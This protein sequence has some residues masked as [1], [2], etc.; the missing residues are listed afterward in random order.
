M[1][2][3]G[4]TMDTVHTSVSPDV[5]FVTT[6]APDNVLTPEDNLSPMVVHFLVV[7]A[8][9]LA[10]TILAAIY[11]YVHRRGR[12]RRRRNRDAGHVAG[13]RALEGRRGSDGEVLC[14]V[15]RDRKRKMSTHI[16]LS[17]G[18][19]SREPGGRRSSVFL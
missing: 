14:R 6:L 15:D 18:T 17:M 13:L 9:V 19:G 16:V 7:L 3:E 2:Y 1:T 5:D 4:V 12:G 8:L 10:N 11:A